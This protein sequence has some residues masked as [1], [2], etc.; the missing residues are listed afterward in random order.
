MSAVA[1]EAPRSVAPEQFGQVDAHMTEYTHTVPLL[2]EHAEHDAMPANGQ[3]EIVSLGAGLKK[4][5]KALVS[6]SEL[7]SYL[8]PDTN[9]WEWRPRSEVKI[10][11]A[12]ERV[13]SRPP[14]TPKSLSA[15]PNRA[16]NL[17]GFNRPFSLT[18]EDSATSPLISPAFELTPVA[19][20]ERSE[21]PEKLLRMAIG[22][23]ALTGSGLLKLTK[24]IGIGI[25]NAFNAIK[26]T[27]V[28]DYNQ[29]TA[30]SRSIGSAT[31]KAAQSA[32]Q[33]LRGKGG[34][35]NL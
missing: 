27:Y 6:R 14:K 24:N 28:E 12:A 10:L 20:P 1:P 2:T 4:M 34:V 33:R 23:I 35:V 29:T 25:G 17:V 15:A 31:T 11:E 13:A 3:E 21:V 19:A 18:V 30:N 22:G 5:G 16:L 7:V 26:N 8:N 32:S 9:D